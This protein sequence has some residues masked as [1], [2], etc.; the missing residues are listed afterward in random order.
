MRENK[1]D[2]GINILYSGYCRQM[3]KEQ[4]RKSNAKL[5]VY[6]TLRID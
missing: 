3:I 4:L 2:Q 5:P 1:I 6:F